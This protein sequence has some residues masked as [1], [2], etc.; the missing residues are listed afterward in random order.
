V[1]CVSWTPDGRDVP[2]GLA[3]RLHYAGHMGP[4]LVC[5]IPAAAVT[6]SALKPLL[7]LADATVSI[8]VYV[9]RSLQGTIARDPE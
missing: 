1:I 7:R 9:R 5:P 2:I 8:N 6:F 3:G 4:F